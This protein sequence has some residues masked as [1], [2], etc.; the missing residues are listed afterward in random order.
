M[1]LVGRVGAG[2][3]G[4]QGWGGV[5][6]GGWVEWT[7]TNFNLLT[8]WG[9]HLIQYRPRSRVQRVMRELVLV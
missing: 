1:R 8:S 7:N 9:A 3:C 2:W 5:V 6:E 4:C